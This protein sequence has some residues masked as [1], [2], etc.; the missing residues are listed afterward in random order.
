MHFDKP[1]LLLSDSNH[2]F[3]FFSRFIYEISIL[4]YA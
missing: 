3:Q 1:S 2:N 4:N